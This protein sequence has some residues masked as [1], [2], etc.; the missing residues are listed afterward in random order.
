MDT[1]DI[2]SYKR[3][4]IRKLAGALGAEVLGV[5]MTCSLDAQTKVELLDA[6]RRFM[7][8]V[9]PDQDI[10]DDD[11]IGFSRHFGELEVY[12][13][14][15]NRAVKNPEIFR[16]SNCDDAGNLLASDHPESL[17]NNLTEYWHTDSTYRP[18]PAKGA[19]LHGLEVPEEGDTIFVNLVAAFEALCVDRQKELE[20]LIATHAWDYGYS[21]AG[22]L[23]KAM[24]EQE[25]ESVPAVQHPLIRTHQET[26][27]KSLFISPGYVRSIDGMTDECAQSL[28]QELCDWSTQPDFIFKHHWRRND[29]VMWDNRPTMHARESFDF[30][31]QRRI[32]HRTTLVGDGVVA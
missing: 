17:W 20:K 28:I 13:L 15:D 12:P 10:S 1:A 6:W 24:D 11:Q 5:D 21:Y 8:L 22:H 4:T 3:I 2:P 9:F 18:I 23:M 19:I 14:S 32:M 7:V 31:N 29:V 30:A 25:L 26:G 27:R 16:A